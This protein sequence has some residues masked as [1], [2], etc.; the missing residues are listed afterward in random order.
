MREDNG[1]ARKEMALGHHRQEEV[2]TCCLRVFDI[3]YLYI[4]IFFVLA[5]YSNIYI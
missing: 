3:D 4:M 5:K 1:S 2:G